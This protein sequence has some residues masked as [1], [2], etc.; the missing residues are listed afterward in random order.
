MKCPRSSEMNTASV[1]PSKRGLELGAA[2]AA[3]LLGQLARCDVAQDGEVQF[4]AGDN[5]ELI[6]QINWSRLAD[7]GQFALEFARA[8]PFFQL[9]GEARI[10]RV[11]VHLRP[12]Q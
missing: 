1:I 2:L 7:I 10:V 5:N 3:R 6:S 12:T 11:R 4:I 9:D 8:L